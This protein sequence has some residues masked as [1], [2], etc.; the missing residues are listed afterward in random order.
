MLTISILVWQFYI[1]YN[2]EEQDDLFRGMAHDVADELKAF[3][4]PLDANNEFIYLDYADISQNPLKGYGEENVAKIK[5]AAQ[6]Y[7]PEEV[8]QKLVP[9]GFKISKV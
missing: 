8:W 3:A 5:A 7:D 6:K 2:G 4:E 1:A 9:G